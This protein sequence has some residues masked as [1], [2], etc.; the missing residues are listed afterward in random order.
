[1]KNPIR[2]TIISVDQARA[3]LK[4]QHEQRDERFPQ[5]AISGQYI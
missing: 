2:A 1:M 3:M 5:L 4:D